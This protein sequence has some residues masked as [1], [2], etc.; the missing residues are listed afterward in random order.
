MG[1]LQEKFIR[2]LR[3]NMKYKKFLITGCGRSG[4]GFY[5]NLM[6]ENGYSCG[7]E[8]FIDFRGIKIKI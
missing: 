8:S 7:H 2:Y 4:T 3:N 6:R 1:I 5:V